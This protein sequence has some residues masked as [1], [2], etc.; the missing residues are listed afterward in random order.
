MFK[1][2][3]LEY[4]KNNNFVPSKKMGQNFLINDGI[5]QNMVSVSNISKEDKV[6]EIGPGLGAITK[7]LLEATDNLV[8]VELDKRLSEQLRKLFPNINLVNDD[9]L[10]V[11]LD[12]LFKKN[13]FDVVKVVANLP[14]S[15]SSMIILRLIKVSQV[16]E[17]N[18]LIQKEM[19]QR[20]LARPNTKDYNAFTVL[21]SLYANIEL[22]IKVP[23]TEFVP[24]PE[25]ESWFI[26]IKKH[27]DFNVDFQKIER[28]LKIAFSARRKKLTSNLGNIY[29]K[30]RVI[31]I[32]KN[33]NWCENSRA[34]DF[35][36]E[37]FVA[38]Y[39]ELGELL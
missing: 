19:A 36:K 34:E 4:L 18:I 3:V 5:K 25:V 16:H 13:N 9:I 38:L 12:E 7:Y 21:I 11:D 20:L 26:S 8:V 15:I 33:N 14:Y 27:N 30:A 23:N 6:L 22:K 35:T 39:N 29:N 37:Q 17:I 1:K 31:E 24:A 28:M 10:R 2:D 32:F